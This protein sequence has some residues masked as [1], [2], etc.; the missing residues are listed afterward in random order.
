MLAAV[1]LLFS[2]VAE[3]QTRPGQ[4]PAGGN[5]TVWLNNL[6]F[7]WG[8]SSGTVTTYEVQY[9]IG[10]GGWS[11]PEMAKQL[12]S[13]NKSSHRLPV[14][15]AMR[16]EVVCLRARAL[17]GPGVNPSMWSEPVACGRALLLPPEPA[18][19]TAT[20][21]DVFAN[22]PNAS[23]ATRYELQY[24][25]DGGTYSGVIRANNYL[26]GSSHRLTA[27][28][29]MQGKKL[30]M[31]VRSVRDLPNGQRGYSKWRTS[32]TCPTVPRPVAA[33]PPGQPPA[34][35][36]VTVWLNNL[37]FNWGDSTGDVT[38]Y[39]V[40]HKIGSGNW[41]GL[42]TVVPISSSD[43]SS[44]K[45]AVTDAM[46][47]EQVCL[48]VRALGGPGSTPSTW[49]GYSC[50]RALLLPPNPATLSATSQDI[51]V[52]W[53][54]SSKATRYELQYQ[55]DGGGFSGVI[56]A[57]NYRDGSSHR[58]TVQSNMHGAKVCVRV[59]SVLDLPSG[60]PGHSNW[61]S[62]SS[63]PTIPRPAGPTTP[64][65][66]NTVN[67]LMNTA[68]F[69]WG[70]SQNKTGYVAQVKG[71][72]DKWGPDIELA[73]NTTSIV[74]P[75]RGAVVRG[76]RVCV[77]VRAVNG[78]QGTTSTWRELPSGS[79]CPQVPLVPP[80]PVEVVSVTAH[81]L[82]FD[83]SGSQADATGYDVQY[84]VGSGNWTGTSPV[85]RVNG[86]ESSHKM[87][88]T[89]SMG[90]QRVCFRFRTVKEFPNGFRA[91]STWR[92]AETCPPVP[93]REDIESRTIEDLI[94][95]GAT[96]ALATASV[97]GDWSAIPGGNPADW[98]ADERRIFVTTLGFD[99][100]TDALAE[101]EIDDLI[102]AAPD[103]AVAAVF[104]EGQKFTADIEV[105][106][107]LS[108]P[109][110]PASATIG[111]SGEV[112]SEL[113][114]P[115]IGIGFART[116]VAT[117]E[118][119][120]RAKAS[121]G[122]AKTGVQAYYKQLN[123]LDWGAE[124]LNRLTWFRDRDVLAKTLEKSRL[125]RN[126]VPG[127]LDRFRNPLPFDAAWDSYVGM[128]LSY[129]ATL[130]PAQASALDAG[131]TDQLPSLYD[132]NSFEVGNMI[133]I[134]GGE[135]EGSL[136]EAKFKVGKV[137]VALAQETNNVDAV[138]FSITRLE[139]TT[140]A[141]MVG[142]ISELEQIFRFGP[143][144]SM[145]IA[146]ERRFTDS[147]MDYA[148]IDL[149][150]SAGYRAYKLFASDFMLPESE[151]A[152]VRL[153]RVNEFSSESRLAAE[154]ALGRFTGSWTLMSGSSASSELHFRDGERIRRNVMTYGGSQSEFVAPVSGNGEPDWNNMSV[155]FVY[156]DHE[157]DGY[158]PILEKVF[159]IPQPR[160]SS[161]RVDI[162]LTLDRRSVDAFRS[163][164]RQ[165]L[166]KHGQDAPVGFARKLAETSSTREAVDLILLEFMNDS[167]NNG[168]VIS[169][170]AFVVGT[171]E[172]P[173]RSIPIT[174]DYGDG[175]GSRISGGTTIVHPPSTGGG[176]GTTTPPP[177]PR[178][179][180]AELVR[181]TFDGD[182]FVMFTNNTKQWVENACFSQLTR[183]GIHARPA[184]WHTEVK[185]SP[186]TTTTL[187]CDELQRLL[188][189][190]GTVPSPEPTPAPTPT[191]TPAPTPTPTPSTGGVLVT[192]QT[193]APGSQDGFVLYTDGTRQWVNVSCYSQ[194][195]AAG[196]SSRPADWTTE[197]K[198]RTTA[199]I[200]N[201]CD[202]LKTLLG[203]GSPAPT[204]QS[205]PDPGME[206]VKTTNNGDGFIV[207]DNGTKQWVNHGC[208]SQLIQ[209]GVTARMVPWD[210]IRNHGSATSLECD[211]LQ[212]R[213]T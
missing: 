158:P 26:D 100:A 73:A 66:S 55:I 35:A 122:L 116:Q 96:R 4:P 89:D 201:S 207:F 196:V 90:G 103:W 56:R 209:A 208:F 203:S 44:H 188:L 212:A 211:D 119:V 109:L 7:N 189:N 14:T 49:R 85:V 3:A 41:T 9:R 94:N 102:D 59:R 65:A 206:L 204:P 153:A 185:L 95:L 53:P 18:T 34:G 117:I 36:N 47:G 195:V 51:Y 180:V 39:E 126:L 118:V 83:W 131:R 190:G 157:T 121:A 198:I 29:A 58:L 129:S 76:E 156:Q 167:A 107:G 210:D 80:S 151:A 62:G 120:A 70:D 133:M 13:T 40:Q 114:E 97:S 88:P 130:S 105:L 112:T 27:T 159:G 193:K 194:L 75:Y 134:R 213:M 199:S 30:C 124:Q 24:Q 183:A 181:V 33:T 147:R 127:P 91:L 128:Q 161:D 72:D 22:W 174:V 154:L 48:R 148:E 45:L 87:T 92:N 175:T 99:L 179:I 140:F 200:S 104:G 164:G 171:Y 106:R 57:N 71:A 16:G 2:G 10:P 74:V 110:S 168:A 178:E 8:D 67:V 77:R 136:Y 23:K 101:S 202:R 42:K 184:E 113:T 79:L 21:S 187:S 15:Y 93:V 205:T 143:F 197:I 25:I 32:S 163:A 162:Q 43:K 173:Y 64:G 37:V 115:Q 150:T 166:N 50:P 108:N 144:K 146:S 123:R 68:T 152:G 82:V 176:G 142:P 141:L 137:P 81:Q 63:C 169:K 186:N 11:E 31:R 86:D 54:T 46:R 135:L 19:L 149:Q 98:T 1:L 160:T 155:A 138:G 61:R 52:D 5:V 28:S 139:G 192:S 177:E 132:P 145:Q 172:A 60:Q 78:P 20:S 84:K 17:G 111:L 165:W 6:A 12:T 38:T 170:L 182:G 191:P 125:L 69:H